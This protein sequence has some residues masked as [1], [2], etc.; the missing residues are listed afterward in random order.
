MG[1]KECDLRRNLGVPKDSQFVRN[2]ENLIVGIQTT[3][4][5]FDYTQEGQEFLR[6]E[7][8]GVLPKSLFNV[9]IYL[10]E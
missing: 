2:K 9:K 3:D 8:T 1:S 4:G 6:S 5:S 10:E 7:V